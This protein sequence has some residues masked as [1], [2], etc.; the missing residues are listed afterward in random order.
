MFLWPILLRLYFQGHYCSAKCQKED[1]EQHR[2]YCKETRKKRKQ[3]KK[4]KA[5]KIGKGGDRVGNGGKQK[6]EEEFSQEEVCRD[7]M[8]K[9]T[10]PEVD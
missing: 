5:K 9:L 4:E 6:E 8:E 3:K 2:G 1:W 10:F 7:K